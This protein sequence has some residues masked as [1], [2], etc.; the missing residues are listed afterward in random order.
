MDK[1]N[2][3]SGVL[4]LAADCFAI[5]S[6]VIQRWIVT[7]TG[8]NYIINLKCIDYYLIIIDL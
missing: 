1:M 8:G 5:A 4:F 7:K 6:L 2:I 3:V